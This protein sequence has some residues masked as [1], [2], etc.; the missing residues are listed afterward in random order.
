[1][2]GHKIF[3]KIEDNFYFSK[4]PPC[5]FGLISNGKSI[6]YNGVFMP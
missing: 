5:N 6:K 1:M 2:D 4:N 3:S